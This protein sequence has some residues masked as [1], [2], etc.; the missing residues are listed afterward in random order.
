M[1]PNLIV[2]KFGGSSVADGLAMKQ[3]LAVAAKDSSVK[4]IIVLSASKGITDKIIETCNLAVSKYDAAVRL[5]EEVRSHHISIAKDALSSA[6]ALDRAVTHINSIIDDFIRYIKGINLLS[7]LTPK[8]I[9]HCLAFGEKLSTLIFHNLLIEKSIKSELAQAEQFIKT[10][11][12]FGK[13]SPDFDKIKELINNPYGLLDKFGKCDIIVTQ[14]FIGSDSDG[15]ITTLGRGGSDYS[16]AILG[17]AC[18]ADEIQIWT[19]VSGVQSAD[20][21]Q[22]D[23]ARTINK[24][25]INEIRELSFF[26]A[27]VLHPD[28]IKPAVEAGITVKVLNTFSPHEQGTLIDSSPEL[29]PQIHSISVKKNILSIKFT[30]KTNHNSSR[31]AAEILSTLSNN[32]YATLASSFTESS[33]IVFVEVDDNAKVIMLKSLFRDCIISYGDMCC[34]VGNNLTAAEQNSIAHKILHSIQDIPIKFFL[35]GSNDE[36]IFIFADAEYSDRLIRNI[37]SLI[38]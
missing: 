21:K 23:K 24:M 26:G 36:S 4:K 12:N 38:E 6:N 28:T 13:A 16:A 25:S 11:S 9:D 5:I 2:M 27:K 32:K 14:G 35:L 3:V 34:I 1:K 18:S 22:I 10:N 31:Q 20:P 33:M 29:T 19:D 7:E 8:M 15:N 37:H 30:F 17:F